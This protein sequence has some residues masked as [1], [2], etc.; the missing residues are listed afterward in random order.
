MVY[1]YSGCI[2]IHTKYSDGTSDVNEIAG[3]AK[4]EGLSW[5]VITDHNSLQSLYNKEEGWYN[6]LAVLSGLEISPEKSD[7]YLAMN[8]YNEIDQNKK[9]QDYINEVRKLG[10]FGFIAH[11]DENIKRKNSHLPLR[12]TDWNVKNFDGI[13]IWNY[14]SDWTDN[15]DPK[16]IVYDYIFRHKKLKGPTCRVLKWWDELNNASSNIVPAI[17]G[18]DAHA[19]YYSVLGVKFKVFTY[20]DSFKIITNY[21]FLENE[22]SKDFNSAKI[23]IYDAI[24]QGKNVIVN[25]YWGDRFDFFA[26]NSNEQVFTG[27]SIQNGLK[28]NIVFKVNQ[29]AKIRLLKNGKTVEE[30]FG[31]EIFYKNPENGKYRVE[32]FVKNHPWIYTNP[33]VI[34][35]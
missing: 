32:A 26:E 33:I 17:G 8:V 20:S 34:K 6:G 27:Y 10:G 29:N 14:L 2:H 11:P 18:V 24:K 3:L 35:D 13:E 16:N 12:W 19:M 21:L 5:I 30:V 31:K 23:Q 15:F 28:T 7:H 9:P 22:L 1:T 25:R 4:K